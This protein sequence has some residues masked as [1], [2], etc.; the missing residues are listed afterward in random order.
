MELTATIARDELVERCKQGDS[1]GYS[2]LYHKY[3][4]AM[5]N[6]SLRIVNNVGDAEDVL[7]DAFVDAFKHLN[8]FRYN[9]T[10]GAWL[11][12][13]VINK[14]ISL[15]RK[16]KLNLVDIESTQV[17]DT[18]DYESVDETAFQYRVDEVRNAIQKLPDGYRAVVSLYLLEEIPQEEIGKM[19]GISHN[20]VRTQF[21]RAKQKLLNILKEGGLS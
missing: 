14:S 1:L 20:T 13:I 3:A 8:D 10:F 11:K 17:A 4:K 5:F 16:K 9:S 19:L 18:S 15:L 12:R 21:H 2:E 7:Q 6:T